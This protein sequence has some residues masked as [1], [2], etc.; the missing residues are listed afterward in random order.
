MQIYYS[1][2][3]G[4]DIAAFDPNNNLKSLEY[5]TQDIKKVFLDVQIFVPEL[6][7]TTQRGTAMIE[8]TVAKVIKARNFLTTS[9]LVKTGCR[10]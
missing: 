3:G 10:D 2:D 4:E 5:Q 7:E 6:Q 9:S 1:I 8:E